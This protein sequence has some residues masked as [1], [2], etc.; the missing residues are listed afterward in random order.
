[1][2]T[3]EFLYLC[4]VFAAFLAFG[5]TLAWGQHRTQNLA[6]PK[7]SESATSADDH[8]FKNAA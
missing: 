5:V 6:G 8:G 2:S 1:M 3:M 7:E 4:G